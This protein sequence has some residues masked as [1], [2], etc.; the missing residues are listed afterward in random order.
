MTGQADR[1]NQL[2][3]QS[4]KHLIG[5]RKE[6][7]M[8]EKSNTEWQRL[9]SDIY[10]RDK[11]MCWICNTFV[12]L[13]EYD[14]GHIIDRSNGGHDGYDNLAVMHRP[15]NH[16]KPYH[17]TLE[18]AMKWKLTAFMPAIQ[19]ARGVTSHLPISIQQHPKR[20]YSPLP[21]K[22]YKKTKPPSPHILAQRKQQYEEQI[23]K[24]KPRTICWIQGRP[25]GGA[26]WKVLPPPYSQEDMFT[27]R[28]TPPGATDNGMG[29][30]FDTIQVI[31]GILTQEVNISL[32]HVN[33]HI[34]PNPNGGTLSITFSQGKKSNI[35]QRSRTVGMG[36]GQIPLEK[37]Y[38]A[39]A[40]GITF[41]DFI[42][43]YP[44]LGESPLTI[45]QF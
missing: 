22:R 27:I 38:K 45:G 33:I 35:D 26:M 11:G 30:V 43:T 16:S 19:Q 13:H 32:G 44:S 18:E 12:P 21:T 9:R 25:M 24:I 40:Q 8:Q 29:S 10:L 5:I 36:I 31:G 23:A 2:F 41:R 14:L 6:L 17:Q 15:C 34:S 7:D 20:Q 42:D 3:A 37:W 4:V 1:I 28:Q 39:K